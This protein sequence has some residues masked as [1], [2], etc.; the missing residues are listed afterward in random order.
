MKLVD[1]LPTEIKTKTGETDYT[2][3]TRSFTLKIET[4]SQPFIGD[5]NGDY[6]D[7]IMYNDANH[8]GSILVAFQVPSEMASDAPMFHTAPFDQALLV[9]DPDEGC[10][11]KT[12]ESKR[13]TVPHSIALIDFDGDC[14]ADLFVTVQDLT[15]GKK[16]Y[17]I[18]LRREIT[19]SVEIKRTTVKT[20]EQGG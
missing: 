14:M 6:L 3:K 2:F 12:I 20:V 15:T 17:E 10:M 4:N 9:R 5:L 18:Y 13:L 8:S 19:E 11:G 1:R 7:D 16:F